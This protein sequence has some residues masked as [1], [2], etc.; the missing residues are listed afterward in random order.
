MLFLHCHCTDT[1]LEYTAWRS[2]DITIARSLMVS[3]QLHHILHTL[4]ATDYQL[5]VPARDGSIKALKY[6][7]RMGPRGK[8]RQFKHEWVGHVRRRLRQWLKV[9]PNLSVGKRTLIYLITW[10]AHHARCK[11]RFVFIISGTSIMPK[12]LALYLVTSVYS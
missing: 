8:G 10:D 7:A 4:N 11:Q 2:L 3:D 1:V 12:P 9:C 5:F 6:M